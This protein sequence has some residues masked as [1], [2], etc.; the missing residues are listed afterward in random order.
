MKLVKIY[1]DVLRESKSMSC[2]V[3]FGNELFD[4]QLSNG[5]N[6]ETN[7]STEDSYLKLIAQFTDQHHGIAVRPAFIDAMKTLKSCMSS[8]PE[9]LQ[10]AGTAYRGDDMTM[11][12]LLAQYEDIEDELSKGGVFDFN[13]TPKTMIQS[14]TSDNSIAEDFA[15][16]SPFLLQMIRTYKEVKGDPKALANFAREI[17]DSLDNITVPIV[18]KLNTTSD[19]FLFKSKYF[20]ILSQHDG[21]EE[22]LRINNQ[23]TRVTG[24]IVKP[25]FE[26]VFGILKAVKQYETH[27]SQQE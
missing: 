17:S 12:D 2:L 4:P 20:T 21:E 5:D 26:S 15:K 22:L 19:D 8:Y 25:L 3:K 7:T 1:E 18:M 24:T 13:Y 9:V 27:K 6:V 10:P 16:T 23:P 14:W 11:N